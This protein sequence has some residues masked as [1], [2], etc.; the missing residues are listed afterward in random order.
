MENLL[1]ICIPTFNR[2]E[3]IRETVNI[4]ISQVCAYNI[5]ICI[6]DNSE[7]DLT[8]NV[9]V[10]LREKYKNIF[11][12]R[13]K[14]NLGI[15]RN[16]VGAVA[17][18]NT[19]YVWIFGDDDEPTIGAI[20]NILDLI[21]KN[22]S[23][24]AF[25]VNSLPMTSDMSQQMSDNLTGIYL[26]KIYNDANNA[27]E[28]ISWY[29]TFVGAFIVNVDFW[30][31]VD[32]SI[33]FDTVFVHVGIL[34]S[35]MVKQNTQ[36]MFISDPLIKYR[37]NNASWSNNFLK[38]QLELWRKTI[39]LL[40]PEYKAKSRTISIESVVFRFVGVKNLVSLR[41]Q[42]LLNMSSLTSVVLPY[43]LS[44]RKSKIKNYKIFFAAIIL[45]CIPVSIVN[46]LISV[47]KSLCAT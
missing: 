5:P 2:P 24:S 14:K 47:G 15:D 46:K 43:F 9:V 3:H 38:I 29:T 21:C 13:N 36:I 44:S 11:Y 26:D 34:Y 12:K 1:T 17:M 30:N 19:K 8:E 41:A 33:F 7:N 27:L 31:S 35:A 40:P 45:I 32:P 18:A 10:E 37:T 22:P 6:S 42:S 23:I 39:D 28:E 20:S 25:I 4:F 16:I